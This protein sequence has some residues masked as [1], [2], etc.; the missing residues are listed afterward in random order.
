MKNELA[1][2]AKYIADK[3][4]QEGTCFAET[5]D[6]FGKLTTYYGMLRKHPDREA[7][8]DREPTVAGFTNRFR[9]VE[10][11]SQDGG[12]PKIRARTGS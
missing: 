4:Q 7:D 9:E 8:E 6:A 12:R 10:Q 2:L 5:L 3:A 11:E 1:A